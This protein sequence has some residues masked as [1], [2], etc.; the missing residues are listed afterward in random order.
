MLL[1]N[2]SLTLYEKNNVLLQC[3]TFNYVCYNTILIRYSEHEIVCYNIGN[4]ITNAKV[5]WPGPRFE[6]LLLSQFSCTQRRKS[7]ATLL[8]FCQKMTG[9]WT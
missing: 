8:V 9:T 3:H 5:K 1:R 7:V 2:Y 6:A 4:A